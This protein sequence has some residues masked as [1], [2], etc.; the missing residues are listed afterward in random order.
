MQHLPSRRQHGFT[1]IELL[2][3]ITILGVLMSGITVFFGTITDARVKGQSIAE[4]ESQGTAIMDA[5]LQ[6]VRNATSITTPATGVTATSL[7]LAMPVASVNPTVFDLSGGTNMGYLLDGGTTDSSDSNS[8]NATK[9]TAAAD[10]TVSMLYA[11]IGPTVAASPNNV[12]Q[13]ALYSGASNPTTLLASSASQKLVANNWNAFSIPTVAVTNGTTY[14]IAYNTNGLVAGDNDLRDHTGA[15]GQSRFVAQAFGTWP[16]SYTGT[17]QNVEFSMYAPIETSTPSVIRIKE[18]A[19]AVVP[20]SSNG[21]QVTG[22]NIKNL[23]RSGTAG[24]V[25]VTFTV[26]HFNPGNQNEFDYRKTFVGSAEV[27]W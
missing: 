23:T 8:V 4:V 12:A 5:I 14:W 15:V 16:A 19:G 26:S 9:F 25:R 13:M 10:G 27:G 11:H 20:I 1:L 2:L 21:V 17:T 7:T 22:F 24:T 3:Y 18:G 6:A